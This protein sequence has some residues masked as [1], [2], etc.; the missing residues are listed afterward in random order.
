MTTPQDKAQM[1]HLRQVCQERDGRIQQLEQELDKARLELSNT[2]E[3]YR[4]LSQRETKSVACSTEDL[5]T[6]EERL[7]RT[8]SGYGFVDAGMQGGRTMSGYGFVNGS[9]EGPLPRGH[10][11][12]SAE[13]FGPQNN[14]YGPPTK[15]MP[16]EGP[17]RSQTPS[18][19]GSPARRHVMSR[20]N[21]QGVS[22]R[23]SAQG[24]QLPPT[25]PSGGRGSRGRRNSAG[26]RS[27]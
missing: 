14:G 6:N 25:P 1:E 11:S 18:V 7:E 10:H 12:Q 20:G 23:G 4:E 9:L 19:P 22:G 24:Y 21:L 15:K 8:A 3:K 26:G 5:P 27:V 16:P 2:T 13:N 17:S